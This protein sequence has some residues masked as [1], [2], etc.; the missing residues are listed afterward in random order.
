MAR[1]RFIIA[2]VLPLF[3]FFTIA[4]KS[5]EVDRFV[6]STLK[7]RN[8]PGAVVA[9]LRDGK[10]V[11]LK[12]YGLASVE[13]G[14]PVTSETVFEIGSV[15]KQIT[16]GAIMLLVEDG[17]VSLDEKVSAYIPNTPA[18]WQDVTVR[19]LLN[20][21]S[22]IPSYTVLG[23]FGLSLRMTRDDFVGKFTDLPLDFEPGTRYA[24]NNS[25]YNL[26]GYIIEAQSGMPYWKFLDERIY[27]PLGIKTAGDRDPKFI[28]R[29]RATGYEF[30][31]GSLTGRDGSLTDLF[32]AGA[33]VMSIEDLVKWE[34]SLRDASL[35]KKESLE[36]MWTPLRFNDGREH[37]YGLGFRL[38]PIR[39]TRLVAHSGQTAGFGTSLSRFADDD[40]TVIAITNL[41]EDGMGT[42]L[43]LG[44]AKFY[45]PKLSLSLVTSGGGEDATL[46]SIVR[47]AIEQRL[48]NSPSEDVFTAGLIRSISSNRAKVRNRRI[49][50]LGPIEKVT[51][52][53]TD[54]SFN[55]D[56]V[57]RY[58]VKTENRYFLWR[59]AF[60]E[61]RRV[62]EMI[63]EEE[64][65]VKK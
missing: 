17:K 47:K 49:A 1:L 15:T 64:E 34:R 52:V 36:E 62:T 13:F 60:T 57:H 58:L 8:I 56:K 30:I 4:A 53:G 65:P 31:D 46:S 6:D 59:F 54:F 19:H 12:G 22:G 25:G 24:Y 7:E 48:A 42:L 61:D 16:A 10:I 63:L 40:L 26:L 29:N 50:A 44:V 38:S 9:V 55:A 2:A 35:L 41:G 33:I 43:A 14:V 23:G 21:T 37:P 28:I 5:D 11:H 51:F 45:L 27:K 18:G 20:H 3:L 32:A 39:G